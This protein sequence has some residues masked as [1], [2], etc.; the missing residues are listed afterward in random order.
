VR[1]ASDAA[2]QMIA[3][4]AAFGMTPAAEQI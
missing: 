4:A 1:V 3:F 2:R